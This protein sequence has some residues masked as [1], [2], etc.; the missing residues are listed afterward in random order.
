MLDCELCGNRLRSDN[1]IG[2]C[3][4]TKECHN[5]RNRRLAKR[6]A[7]AHPELVAQRKHD[8]HEKHRETNNK[9]SKQWRETNYR[10][11]T[12]NQI[13]YRAEKTGVLFDLT[14]DDIPPVPDVCPV[15]NT[16]LTVGQGKSEP[17]SPSLDRIIPEK[18]YVKGN[19]V[20]L[21]MRA[22]AMKNDGTAE[23]H[24]RIADWIDEMIAIMEK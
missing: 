8:Y 21:S 19:I 2:I 15:F 10:R 6:Y 22:N 16:L 24:R 1:K 12:F 5:E 9:R 11:A 7:E 4:R 23:E 20:W 18:G 3:N 17:N 14:L 13:K